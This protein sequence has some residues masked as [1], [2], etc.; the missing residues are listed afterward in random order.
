MQD[1]R[2]YR[3]SNLE[4]ESIQHAEDRKIKAKFV[5]YHKIHYDVSI[6]FSL[7]LVD[8]SNLVF[9][10]VDGEDKFF[11]VEGVLLFTDEGVL[12]FT[13]EGVL[14]FTEEGILD[15]VELGRGD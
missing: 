4:R 14:L 1:G 3:C 2:G 11:D 15:A 13:D 7:I 8:P 12:L 10:G 5:S 6:A 9:L